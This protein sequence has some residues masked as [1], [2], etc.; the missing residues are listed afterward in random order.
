MS[1]RELL[2]DVAAHR[3]SVA[4]EA[5]PSVTA[6][7][8]PLTAY[9]SVPPAVLAN[10]AL[11]GA[12]AHR[13]VELHDQRNLNTASLHPLVRPYLAAYVAFRQEHRFAPA[14]NEARLWHPL[15]RFAGTLDLLGR[16]DEAPALIDLK[17]TA[18][19]MPSVG[20]QTAAYKAAAME[21]PTLAEPLRELARAARRYCL[22]L[23][24]DGTYQLQ[25]CDDPNDWAVFLSALTLHTFKQKHAKHYN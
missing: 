1:A 19:L 8:A 7:L 14:L 13:A 5:L 9:G 24:P 4:G 16:L 22:Q 18:E 2:F 10:K 11:L 12:A 17:C 6:I 15:H 3:Y 21:S 25:P 20:P 23:R